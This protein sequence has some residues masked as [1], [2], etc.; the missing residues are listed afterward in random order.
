MVRITT[1][2]A[3]GPDAVSCRVAARPSITGILMSI[4]TTSGRSAAA[5]A[6]ASAPSAA[7]PTTVQARC[8]QDQPEPGADQ[9]LVVGDEHAQRLRGARGIKA[10][11]PAGAV[12]VS[13][14]RAVTAK[15]P[16]AVGPS[17]S[18]PP[19]DATRSAMPARP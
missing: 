4:S 15:P 6:T 11:R 5:S 2:G 18:A 3:C 17:A 16:S 13:G 14:N 10:A 7:S 8:L 1:L 19:Q 12:H 9:F